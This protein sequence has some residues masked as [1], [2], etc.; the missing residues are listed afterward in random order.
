MVLAACSDY[1]YHLFKDLPEKNPVI[2]FNDASEQILNDLLEFMYRGEVEVNDS[3]LGDFVKIANTLQIKGLNTGEDNNVK[4]NMDDT[5][6]TN[7]GSVSV[8]SSQSGGS[9]PRDTPPISVEENVKVGAI[10]KPVA[11]LNKVYFNN[12][13]AG[14][15][16]AAP[17][18][19]PGVPSIG[20]PATDIYTSFPSPNLFHG[21][22]LKYPVPLRQKPVPMLELDSPG[23]L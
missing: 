8:S 14:H 21:L 15:Q 22:K 23:L 1:F 10:P 19:Y 6:D 12:A 7:G 2:V 16:P 18:F 9:T 17:N 13:Q 11:D 3:N 4:K 5:S 20:V